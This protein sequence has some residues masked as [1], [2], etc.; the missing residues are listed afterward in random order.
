MTRT[1]IAAAA[2]IV[3][4]ALGGAFAT[5]SAAAAS[6]PRVA[7]YTPVE[8]PVFNNIRGSVADQEAIES[9]INA[10]IRNTPAGGTIRI[11]T[12]KLLYAETTNELVAAFQRGV[13]VRIVVPT[14]A[15][16]DPDDQILLSV[17]GADTTQKSYITSCDFACGSTQQF[18]EMHAKIA[19]FS[20]VGSTP[21]VAVVSSANLTIKMGTIAW[22]DAYQTVNRA[23]IYDA[24]ATYVDSLR[25]DSSPAVTTVDT[26]AFDLYLFPSGQSKATDFYTKLYDGISCQNHP[27]VRVGTSWWDANRMDIARKIVK[28]KKAG[29]VIEV[30]LKKYR[31]A[32]PVMQMLL[33]G[34]VPV[35]FSDPGDGT[36]GHIK[37]IVVSGGGRQDVFTGSANLT[38][39]STK[40]CDETMLAVHGTSAVSRYLQ[41]FD[42]IWANT[43]MLTQEILDNTHTDTSPA[44]MVATRD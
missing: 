17:L 40:Y 27:V 22:N 14:Q 37:Y 6:A 11:S 31:T 9:V 10:D 28:L 41:N 43:P 32:I 36:Y 44:A 13:N 19:T 35:H 12:L 5:S 20:R 34:Q 39:T 16:R 33:D 7:P 21:R 25:P 18:S 29:C 2:L 1:R 4:A 42:L 38:I 15:L 3:A 23:K 24:L 26:A 30:I 8:G